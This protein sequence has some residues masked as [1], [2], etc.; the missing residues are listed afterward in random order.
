MILE[1]SSEIEVNDLRKAHYNSILNSNCEDLISY[2]KG[3]INSYVKKVFLKLEDNTEE[4]EESFV[5]LSNDTF[6]NKNLKL[7]VMYKYD[8]KISDLSDIEELEIKT[9]LI[10]TNK[11]ISNWNNVIDY[12]IDCDSS[13][14]KPLIDFLN[15]EENYIELSKEKMDKEGDFDYAE[16]R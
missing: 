10:K 11:V 4:P 7:E 1:Y 15:N 12:Y 3:D 2:L 5:L 9:M 14:E 8:F 13:I 16:F 6:L